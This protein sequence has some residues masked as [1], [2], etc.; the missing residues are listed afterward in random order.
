M[1]GSIRDASVTGGGPDSVRPE[2]L[3][4]SDKINRNEI[5]FQFAVMA[6]A[7]LC[8]HAPVATRLRQTANAGKTVI[9]EHHD[10]E[11]VALL[12]RGDNFLGHHQV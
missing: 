3:G 12:Q 1:A 6:I 5:A 11:F 7:I 9:V 8:S 4:V 10:V 2:A